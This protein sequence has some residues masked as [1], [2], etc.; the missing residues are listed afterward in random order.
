[1][2][3]TATAPQQREQKQPDTPP[4]WHT[5]DGMRYMLAWWE[6]NLVVK[7]KGGKKTVPFVPNVIQRKLLGVMA[8]QRR[9]GY[10]VRIIIL[11]ARQEGCSTLVAA[12][13][14]YLVC[15][16]SN[17]NAFVCAHD[18]KG[19]SALWGKVQMYHDNNPRV[20]PN[21]LKYSSARE[22]IWKMPHNST[23]KVQTAGS[24]NI[25]RSDTFQYAH[26][27]EMPFWPNQGESVDS[28]TQAVAKDEDSICVIES[29]ANGEGDE[30]HNRWLSAIQKQ[31]D[32]F[33]SLDS[34]IPVFFSWMDNPEYAKPVPKGLF[35][36]VPLDEEERW[37]YRVK[38]AT[39]EQLYWRRI[40]LNEESGGDVERFHAAYPS[41]PGEAF[42]TSGRP[43]FTREIIGMHRK[44]I[45]KPALGHFEW[46]DETKT[47]V[48]FVP[49]ETAD[50]KTDN[51]WRI[52]RRPRDRYDYAIGADVA[53]GKPSD[54]SDAKS[55]SDRSAIGVLCR[56]ELETCA[57]FYG[58]PFPEDL[59]DEMEKACVY[60][61]HAYMTPEINNHGYT[62]LCKLLA[63][64]YGQYV[65]RREGSREDME[66][67]DPD[68]YGWV[69]KDRIARDNLI[70][71]WLR[72]CR[73]YETPEIIKCYDAM[74]VHEE[75]TFI[76]NARGKREHKPSC[77]DDVLF[78]HMIALRVH[79]SK[80]C[81]R[82]RSGITVDHLT[83]KPVAGRK[84]S[85]YIGGYDEGVGVTRT[86]D[87]DIWTTT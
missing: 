32:D 60:Y 47:Q 43:A 87:E 49:D 66:T 18:A 82:T 50:A 58:R 67:R 33:G 6:R 11:K 31:R 78:A 13:F 42:L 62:T 9:A 84:G 20:V 86:Y 55:E 46:A 41:T 5:P 45:E 53:E 7:P 16:T 30:F 8:R 17:V 56:S 4:P 12:L 68:K 48:R 28:V 40:I 21:D 36:R 1:L 77:F 37:L 61:N 22:L 2:T 76:F 74:L 23:Y 65:Y 57:V 29:T 38:K 27:S 54:P 81:P 44:T 51:V 72:Y 83:G 35:Q 25:G 14:Y 59:A 63:D 24:T 52:Y 79:L 85:Q 39:P 71:E 80:S 26:L 34:Y 64:G 15:A 10:P 3:T 70:H 73:G 69:T 19:S 75:S